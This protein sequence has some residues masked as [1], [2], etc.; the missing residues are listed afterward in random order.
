M[1]PFHDDPIF[2]EVIAFCNSF[3]LLTNLVSAHCSADSHVISWEEKQNMS[4]QTHTQTWERRVEFHLAALALLNLK[5]GT[6]L[7]KTLRLGVNNAHF[8]IS[9]HL[10]VQRGLVKKG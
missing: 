9:M 4:A 10:M 3:R 7:L 5:F 1:I 2:T 6:Y 8:C